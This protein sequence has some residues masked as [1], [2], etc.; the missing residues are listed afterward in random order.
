MKIFKVILVGVFVSGLTFSV[1]PSQVRG[2]DYATTEDPNKKVLKQALVG[3]GVGAIAAETSGGKAGQGALIGAGTNVIGS[4]ILDALT[5]PPKPQP[6]PQ[7]VYVPQATE[8]VYQPV[9]ME[10]VKRGGCARNR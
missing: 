3:A 2:Q 1:T 6:Q 5:S 7:V 9:D 10:P 8:K 4:A